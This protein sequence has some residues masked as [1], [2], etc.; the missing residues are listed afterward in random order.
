MD[1]TEIKSNNITKKSS[2]KTLHCISRGF[3][4]TFSEFLDFPE[5]NERLV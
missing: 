2:I 4:M 1:K 5:I 3:G